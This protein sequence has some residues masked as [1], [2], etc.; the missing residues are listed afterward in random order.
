MA[1]TYSF[2]SNT[3]YIT[4]VVRTTL[5]NF[6]TFLLLLF[7]QLSTT[8]GNR[9][10]KSFTGTSAATPLA[11]G[12]IAL[13]LQ[14]KYVYKTHSPITY[15]IIFSYSPA[16]TWRDVQ[17]LIVYTANAEPFLTKKHL[18][19]WITNGAGLNVSSQFGF[20][21][22][23]AEAMVIHARHWINV[24]TQIVQEIVPDIKS[25]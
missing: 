1:V 6:L 13:A 23:D 11:A 2:S 15:S 10:T 21:A 16:L 4:H 14:A 9:C 22:I 5:K 17:Y 20:G 3:S 24:P 8:L 18:P 7:T 19:L 12:V 25:M